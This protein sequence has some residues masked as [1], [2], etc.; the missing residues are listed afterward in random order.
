MRTSILALVG[1]LVGCDASQINTDSDL[2]AADTDAHD[3]ATHDPMDASD[4]DSAWGEEEGF[5]G[6]AAHPLSAGLAEDGSASVEFD[7]DSESKE[8]TEPAFGVVHVSPA[9]GST[10]RIDARMVVAFN[11]SIDPKSVS[12]EEG[13]VGVYDDGGLAIPGEASVVNG[14]LTFHPDVELA[15]GAGYEFWIGPQVRATTGEAIE[16]S[17]SVFFSTEAA[18]EMEP[19]GPEVPEGPEGPDGIEAPGPGDD[20]ATEDP[21]PGEEHDP[22]AEL[23]GTLEITN[24]WPVFEASIAPAGDLTVEFAEEI[25][26]RMVYIGEEGMRLMDQDGNEVKGEV[27]ASGN[28]IGFTPY[29]EQ[30]D[31]VAYT[32][33]VGR[34]IYSVAGANLAERLVIPFQ[35]EEK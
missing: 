13:T 30:T 32:L 9:D 10:V 5:E 11:A 18:P 22:R 1:L 7:L 24:A 35:V 33:E 12:V 34:D 28:T 16:A 14:L 31:A 29:W 20:G 27:W 23:E 25:D 3:G 26:A 21:G 4:M 17:V 15:Y 19:E 8:D 2:H 6:F